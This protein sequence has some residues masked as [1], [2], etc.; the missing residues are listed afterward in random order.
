MSLVN[1]KVKV[2]DS[3]KKPTRY[4][5]NLQEKEVAKELNGRQTKNSGATP[6]QKGDVLVNDW[7]LEC[8]TKT[9][10]VDTFSI[11]KEWIEKNKKEALFMG[12]ENSAIV[13]NFGPNEENYYIIDEF[14][15][16]S[17]INK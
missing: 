8:K 15:F 1:L 4:Y 5:S 3:K 14:T 17:L 6:W 10:K 16:K 13:F 7:L 2:N 11:K 9:T 12:K